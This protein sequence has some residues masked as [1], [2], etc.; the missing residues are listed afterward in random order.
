MTRGRRNATAAAQDAAYRGTYV[1]CLECG[2]E[3]AYDWTT[4]R[5]GHEL[6]RQATPAPVVAIPQTV[7]EAQPVYR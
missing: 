3:F 6:A 1:V 2:A 4:M 7:R 5:V